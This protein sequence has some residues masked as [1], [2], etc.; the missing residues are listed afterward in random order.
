M[1]YANFIYSILLIFSNIYPSEYKVPRAAYSVYADD[2]DLDGDKD[3]IVG[4]LTAWEDSNK[5][6]SILK[7]IGNGIFIIYDTSIVFCGYQKNIFVKNINNDDYPDLITFMSDFSSGIADRYI[8]IFYNENGFFNNFLDF[9]LNSSAT[10]S[11]INSGDIDNDTY[12]DI[13]VASGKGQFWGVLYNDGTGL[14]SEP[15]YHNVTGYFPTDLACGNLNEDDRNDVAIC[16]QKTE[17]FF[18]YDTGFKRLTLEENSFKDEIEFADIDYDGDQDLLTLVNLYLIGYTGITIY[19][20]QG[21][22]SFFRHDQI[23]FQPAL[24]YFEISDVDR[25][26]YPD[27]VCTGDYGIYVL[28]NEGEYHFSDPQFYSVQN[29]GEGLRKSFCA[30]LNG[31]GYDDIITIRYLHAELPSN[32]NILFNDGTGQFIENPPI[33]IQNGKN[34]PITPDLNLVN[35]PNPFNFS[36]S[37]NFD[38]PNAFR[39]SLYVY[40][41]SGELIDCLINDKELSRGN[42]SIKWDG[43]NQTGK[44]V[45][46]GVYTYT[47]WINNLRFSKKML[48]VK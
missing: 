9:S 16:A 23:L 30:D 25:N 24:S 5:T 40:N 28:Y 26:N 39:V 33:G 8:R 43:R 48:L 42:H 20:N 29:F 31:N 46:S 18:S 11:A 6:I 45:S 32:L 10:F 15:Q 2:L 7:N 22:E 27:M 1:K 38:L 4:H 19:E 37:I 12:I 3:I 34:I 17:I 47:L 36:T 21:N 41:L 44:E 13:I 14:F 35:Y